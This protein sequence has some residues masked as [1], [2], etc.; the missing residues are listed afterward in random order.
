VHGDLRM[1]S[2]QS[3]MSLFVDSVYTL[4]PAYSGRFGPSGLVQSSPGQFSPGPE[5]LGIGPSPVQKLLGLDWTGLGRTQSGLVH[6]WT[7]GIID[8]HWTLGV[9]LHS[10]KYCTA[11]TSINGGFLA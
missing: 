7:G 1:T 9:M 11:V 2:E 10:G 8:T 4:L 3:F 6:C 5:K